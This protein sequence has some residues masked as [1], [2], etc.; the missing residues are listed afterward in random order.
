MAHYILLVRYTDQGIRNIKDTTKRATAFQDM[1]EKMGVKV[2]SIL[3]TMGQYD[4][5][6]HAEAPN[7]ETA[8]ALSVSTAKQGNISIQTLRGF[9]AGEVDGILKI[10]A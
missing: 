7:D 6:V 3:W 8:G 2:S 10:V 9:T 1:A 4:L 5:V